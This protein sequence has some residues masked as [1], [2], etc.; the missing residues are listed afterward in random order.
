MMNY[1]IPFGDTG[2]DRRIH[3]VLF[4]EQ[5]KNI[6]WIRYGVAYSLKKKSMLISAEVLS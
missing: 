2:Y 5:L 3:F 6:Q 1:N 4:D